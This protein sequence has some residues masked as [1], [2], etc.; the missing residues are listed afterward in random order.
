MAV[1]MFLYVLGALLV[2][3]GILII[4]IVIVRQSIPKPGKT[5]VK[6]GGV[7]IVGPIPIVF[8]TDKKMIKTILALS[9]GL[10]AL[11]LVTFVVF[12]LLSR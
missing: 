10:T 1:S 2:V 5:S 6:A 11:V 3:F 4:L 12:Y 8:G 9:I 7:I